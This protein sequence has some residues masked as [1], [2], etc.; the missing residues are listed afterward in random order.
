MRILFLTPTLFFSTIHISNKTRGRGEG[1]NKM[2]TH[3]HQTSIRTSFISRLVHIF[4]IGAFYHFTPQKLQGGGDELEYLREIRHFCRPNLSAFVYLLKNAAS[5]LRFFGWRYQ[6]CG[7]FSLKTN[8]TPSPEPREFNLLRQPP[9]AKT[10]R[11]HPP[12]P[13]LSL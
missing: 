13:A 8:R 7:F 9:A 4:H 3:I 5:N 11:N 1:G 2:Q 10:P 12:H 6:K